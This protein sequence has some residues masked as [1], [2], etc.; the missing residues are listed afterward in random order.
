MKKPTFA[1]KDDHTISIIVEKTTDVPL[2]QIIE[3]KKKLLGQKAVVE[4]ALKN[5]E[6]ILDEAKRLGIIAK[7]LPT[8]GENKND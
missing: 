8:K 4:E 1:K 3:N 5:I 6:V 7:V 2:A